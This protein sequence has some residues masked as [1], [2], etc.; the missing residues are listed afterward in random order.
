MLV[1]LSVQM[2]HVSCQP[3]LESVPLTNALYLVA[4][5]SYSKTILLSPVRTGHHTPAWSPALG[6]PDPI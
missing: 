5:A 1:M 2:V 6:I 3:S 4:P